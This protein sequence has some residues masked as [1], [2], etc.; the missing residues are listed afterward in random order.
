MKLMFDTTVP[1]DVYGR[2]VD[3]LA[4]VPSDLE[5]HATIGYYDDDRIE[6][7]SYDVVGAA[8]CHRAERCSLRRGASTRNVLLA[9]S[10]YLE[11]AARES[12]NYDPMQC[13]DEMWAC[14]ADAGDGYTDD[15]AVASYAAG[16]R[17]AA[18]QMSR[19]AVECAELLRA[20]RLCERVASETTN[21]VVRS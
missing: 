19:H 20:A 18:E 21:K 15:K 17:W 12:V 7:E 5:L 16:V 2:M 1:T 4:H 3:I 14:N 10:R 9:V 8:R 13:A 6:L 11:S